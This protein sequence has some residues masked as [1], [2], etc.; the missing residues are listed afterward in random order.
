MRRVLTVALVL[1]A[2]WMVGGALYLVHQDRERA[3]WN[4]A[5]DASF[6]R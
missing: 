4:E 2:A 1:F 6:S 5:W 3:K